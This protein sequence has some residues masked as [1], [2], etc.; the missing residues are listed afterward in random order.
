M[1]GLISN[2]LNAS[3]DI[4]PINPRNKKYSNRNKK[5]LMSSLVLPQMG[6]HAQNRNTRL[7]NKRSFIRNP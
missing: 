6:C 4:A 1:I 7:P 3:V 5:M 2:G